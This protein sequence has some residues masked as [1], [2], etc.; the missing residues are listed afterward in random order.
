MIKYFDGAMGTM[1]DLKAGELPEQLN[2]TNPKKI[3]AIHNAYSSAGADII[4]ANTFG[5]NRLK[6]RN[7]AEIVRAGVALAKQTGKKV[8]LDIGPTGKLLKP[9]GDLPFEECI[10]IFSE[11]VKAGS[12]A[13]YILL[14]TMSDTLEIKAGMIAAKEN[15]SLPIIV[16]MIFD[17]NGRL[18]TGADIKT[19]CALVEA[20]GASAVGLNC[21]L[22]PKH[23]IPLVKELKKHSSLPIIVMPNAGLPESVN[24]K[25]FYNVDNQIFAKHMV[26]IAKIGVSY[27]GGCCGTTPQHIS[28]MISATKNI[29]DVIP[30]YKTRTIVTSYSESV[31]FSDKSVIIGERIN[32]TGK[33]LLK[34]ALRNRDIDYILREGIAQRD[35]GADILDVNMGLPDINET[36]LL[37]DSVQELQAI[38][39]T[40]LQIDS[41]DLNALEGALRIYNGKP[42]I[43]SVNGKEE[44]MRAVFPLAKKYGGVIVCLCLDEN[45]IPSSAEKRIEIA[46]KIVKT[47]KEYGINK[48]DLIIDAL[49][50]T[51]S[52]DN[53]NAVETLKAVKYIKNRLKLHTVLG[54]SNI[55]FG[56]PNREAINAS[57]YTLALQSGLS[58][59]IINPNSAAMMNAYCSYNALI[60]LD[61]NCAEYINS[62]VKQENAVSLSE[63][64]LSDSIIKG[65]KEESARLTKLL[66]QN[67]NPLDII[68]NH[69]I[70]ALDTVGERFEKNTLFLPQLLMSADSAKSAFDEIKKH[71]ILNGKNSENGNTVII[72][73]VEGDIHDI[74]KNIVKVLLSNYG[75]NVIDLGKDIKCEKVLEAVLK[76]DAKLVGLSALMTTTVVNM[77]KTIDLIHKNSKAKVFVGGAVLTR[78]YAQKI[79][80]DWY[81]KDAMESVR[82]AQNFFGNSL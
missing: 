13:D 44:S 27:L 54:V 16:S 60:G 10:D 40:P 68:N 47:A 37:V 62:V 15:C 25:T 67:T 31:D 9:F 22:G 14:E 61:S 39:S 49:T 6:Y 52:T 58:A 11:M 24:G 21:G 81:A 38:L 23:M 28:S 51:V 80:A 32:P 3:L 70:T 41:A 55:S 12:D 73:T 29:K 8:A 82:I 42:M 46:K 20:L 74:G 26:E 64:T 2:L 30:K 17:E 19:A 76:Y 69:I 35:A 5:A 33:K 79:N 65:I 72:A 36:E 18:L 43:N 45:G 50:M 59:A 7:S 75:F 53:K 71:L 48:K 63:M 56:L 4:T 78:H 1:L 34:E 57:F 77:E 66:L